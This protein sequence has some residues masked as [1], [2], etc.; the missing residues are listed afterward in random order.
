MIL[1]ATS[2]SLWTAKLLL[3]C[4]G[5]SGCQ[6]MPRAAL[7]SAPDEASIVRGLGAPLEAEDRPV[8]ARGQMPGE[9]VIDLE[10]ALRIAGLNN[11]TIAIADEI[12]RQR[13]AERLQARA[14]LFPTLQTGF[15]YRDH[16][17]VF[18]TSTGSII[19]TDEQSLFYGFGADVK[20]GG[21]V[22]DPGLSLVVHLGDAY[23]APQAAQQRVT[24]SRF[25]AAAKRH[26]TLLDVG[27]GYLA[28][29]DAQAR[30]AAYQQS[31]K[32]VDEIVRLTAD[33]AK[34]GQGRD[35]DAKRALS[36]YLLL[37]AALERTQEEIGVAS[38]ELA[39]LL[40]LDPSAGLRSAEL[41]PP[42]YD[43]VDPRLSLPELLEWAK[44]S[45]PEIVARSADVRYQEI[46]VRQE[47][48]RPLLPLIA[49]GLSVGEF[50]GGATTTTPTYGNFSTRTEVFV[51][52]I[53]TLQNLGV[54]NRA[55]QNVARTALS[56]A[57]FERTQLLDRI[58][59]EVAEA[60]SLIQARR[61]E[62][63]LARQRV[64]TS[65]R[66]FSL[67]LTRAKNLLALPIEVL[68][69]VD[70]LTA[71]RQDLIRAMVGY[72]QAQ[73]QL[74]VALGNAPALPEGR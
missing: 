63:D 5:L 28:L 68:T 20:G 22:L 38:A 14:L 2:W 32:D 47:K 13:L 21:T 30:Y 31:L 3:L 34:A 54:G 56:Q 70:Q 40:D 7:L 8:L 26:Y 42:L 59:R 67:E 36:E 55:V 71:A 45:H 19:H 37:Q 16:R 9:Q 1:R 65:Q 6:S 15:N 51:A 18:Q 58:G 74:Y 29:V 4:A 73:L 72:N 24:Q 66:S 11:P 60:Y 35:P 44:A 50:G 39:R 12:V 27:V 61:A 10:T 33:Q 52:A 62:I 41:V 64:E 57:Q 25:D 49:V 43:V 48:A 23:Y 46:R 69:T 53:W 17:G